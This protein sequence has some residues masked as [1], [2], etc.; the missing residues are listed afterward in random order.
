MKYIIEPERKVPI[1]ATVDVVV[2]GGG[3]AGVA[4]SISAARTGAR[5]LLIEQAGAVGGVAVSGLMS[6]WTGDTRGGIYDE[7][8]ERSR[9]DATEAGKKAGRRAINTEKLRSALLEMLE[10][11][12]VGLRL[13]TF[14]CAPVMDGNRIEGVI[15]ESKSGREAVLGRMVVDS[16][17][18]GDIAAR[19]GAPF[20]KGRETDGRMQ[21]MTLMFKVAGVDTDRAPFPG[22]FEDTA[23]VPA[24][25]LQELGRKH[26]PPP[27]GH[28]L[29]YR[30]TLPGVVTCNMTNCVDVDG[31]I[32]SDLTKA[33]KTCRRQVP[34]IVKFLREYVPGFENC[35]LQGTAS[36]IG[37]R[38]TRHFEGEYT[39][40][41]TDIVEARVFDDWVV[42]KAH[43][44][45]DV[46]NLSG[47]GLDPTGK[48]KEFPQKKPFTIPYRCLI[49]KK[50]ENLLLA[51]RCISGTHLAHSAFRVM[52]ICANMG[53]AAGIA[54]ALCAKK[55]IT[56]L[57]LTAG[58]VQ[59]IL[60]K[61]G[62]DL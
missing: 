16:S 34:E 1:A 32:A 4:A 10:E 36:M 28:V 51:G 11:A 40:N 52:P 41:E 3:P 2:V 21:P 46:H 8:L 59:A 37:V 58:E 50:V 49:P 55:E 9:D 43:F 27:A 26:L 29:L 48:Q 30:S 31:T 6:H 54:A 33:E 15:V 13:Y 35:C 14:A 23:E 24:G 56:P 19:A 12:G 62:V 25:D 60:K 39:L 44:N 7:I 20:R 53:Q 5:T 17:G 57:E 45:F 61:Q 22:G 42:T 38:E 47:A 18:D